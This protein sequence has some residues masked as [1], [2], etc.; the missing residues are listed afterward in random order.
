[1]GGN[2]RSLWGLL[3]FLIFS[4]NVNSQEKK[5]K[6]AKLWRYDVECE[7]VSKNGVKLIK[8]WSYSKKTKRIMA[9]ALKNAV[10]GIIFKGYANGAR[11]C[12]SFQPLVEDVTSE[13]KFKT[14]FDTFFDK[15]GEYLNYVSSA[16][17]GVIAPGDRLKIGKREY[18][19]GVI[20]NVLS[21]QLR[22]RLKVAGIIKK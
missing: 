17:G 21:D 3:V 15:N 4:L 2:N 19:I 11:G 22:E 6:D 18:K 9:S 16:T 7:G 20:V 13:N 5:N 14:F 8:V 10:H 1:M 12:D